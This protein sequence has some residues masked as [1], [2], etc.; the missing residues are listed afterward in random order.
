MAC[1]CLRRVGERTFQQLGLGAQ[2][3]LGSVQPGIT[4]RVP[5]DKDLSDTLDFVV[6]LTLSV[7]MN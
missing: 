4:F 3:T 6:G 7:H 1:S 5:L 2:V